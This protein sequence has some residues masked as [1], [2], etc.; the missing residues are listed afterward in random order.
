MYKKMKNFLIILCLLI[1]LTG[2]NDNNYLHQKYLD[3]GEKFYTGK[4]DSVNFFAGNERVKFIWKLNADP[5]ISKCVFYWDDSK[6]K[7][8]AV[9][10]VNRTQSGVLD[11]D[12]ILN[13]KE[14]IYIFNLVTK[15]DENH[16]SLAVEKTVQVYG[17][18]YIS[19]L[20]NR[21]LSSAVFKKGTLTFNWV[22]IENASIHYSTVYYMD[23]S[24]PENPV[25]RSARVENTDTQTVIEGV[26]RG[27]IFS[28][29]TSYFP[30]G[31]LDTLDALPVEYTVLAGEYQ[32]DKI[33]W[34]VTSNNSVGT[35]NNPVTN[36]ID[37]N[38]NTVWFK[39]APEAPPIWLTID[40]QSIKSVKRIE[41]T[42][43]YDVRETVVEGSTDGSNWTEL[44]K[45][46]YTGGR[47][48]QGTLTLTEPV[49]AQYLRFTITRSSN[50]DGRGGFWEINV[51]GS[52]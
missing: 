7:D 48:E 28:I 51:I 21:N 26:R 22:T 38:M 39:D 40:M 49:T 27:D 29:S 16:K 9:V 3:Q 50:S 2:C 47:Q 5:R 35:S 31:G 42:Q 37:G 14:G 32:L 17:P 20:S 13:V 52:D 33:G 18:T 30:E 41:A 19:R 34:T 25:S 45:I 6:N 43:R 8:S 10:H 46:I 15:D 44:G 11:M 36:V 1:Y 24:D 4:A 12:T 23:Y